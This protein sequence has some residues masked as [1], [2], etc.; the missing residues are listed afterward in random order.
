[1]NELAAIDCKKM[2]DNYKPPVIKV[3]DIMVSILKD[4]WDAAKNGQYS[5]MGYFIKDIGGGDTAI[6][7]KIK[8]ALV[9]RGFIVQIHRERDYMRKEAVP[10]GEIDI[11]WR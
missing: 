10:N 7:Y 5:L 6:I 3:E 9:K 1:M 4:I 2:A 11:I 8:K